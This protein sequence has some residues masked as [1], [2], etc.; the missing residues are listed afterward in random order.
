MTSWTRTCITPV[1]TPARCVKSQLPRGSRPRLAIL[2]RAVAPRN[3]C[4]NISLRVN[5]LGAT[6]GKWC[7]ARDKRARACVAPPKTLRAQARQLRELPHVEGET[8]ALEG[9]VACASAP[10]M[11]VTSA[12]CVS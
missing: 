12:T 3:L 6:A 9:A 2:M 10:W 7:G 8:P 1:S 4:R 11:A 5:F